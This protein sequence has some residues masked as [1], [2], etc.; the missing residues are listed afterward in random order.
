MSEPTKDEMLRAL[1][2]MYCEWFSNGPAD[3][4]TE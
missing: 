2:A 1:E 3:M 4:P